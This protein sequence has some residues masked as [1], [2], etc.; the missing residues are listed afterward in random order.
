[1]ELTTPNSILDITKT[2]Q[3]NQFYIMSALSG[4]PGT[5]ANPYVLSSSYTASSPEYTVVIDQW[6]IGNQQQIWVVNDDNTISPYL[7]ASLFLT[8]TYDS[9]G[10]S[11]TV[12]VSSA[13]PSNAGQIWNYTDG[14]LSTT[15]D[16]GT[17]EV[18]YLNVWNNDLQ[19]GAGVASYPYTNTANEQW[20]LVPVQS[21]PKETC[22]YIQTQMPDASGD[23]AEYVI[24]VPG[25]TVSA[26]TQV[27]LDAL[28]PGSLNQLWRV[29]NDGYIV[30]AQD[31][32]LALTTTPGNDQAMTLEQ[33]NTSLQNWQLL[34]NGWLAIGSSG[35]CIMPTWRAA[36]MPHPARSWF[37]IM[38]PA[39]IMLCGAWCR[40]SCRAYGLP[41]SL[42]CPKPVP[43]PMH[44]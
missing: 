42:P 1:M 7:D 2:L 29:N 13:N 40:M 12:S 17:S 32:S 26:G 24:T 38:P 8:S 43:I 33:L 20:F 35:S 15:T 28:Q 23:N 41:S 21:L 4:A 22:F 25:G 44:Y 39:P 30:S 34:P 36:A 37:L 18:D 5:N 3:T 31:A 14:M 27:V 11:N 16:G 19:S 9:G 10:S 6:S